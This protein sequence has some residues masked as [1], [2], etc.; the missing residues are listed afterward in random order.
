M[1]SGAEPVLLPGRAAVGLVAA[2][3][4]LGAAGIE[5]YAV[6]GGVAVTVRLGRA[7]R[8]TA[9][10]DAV[11][12]E[13]VPPD[14]VEALVE[15]EG[16]ERDPANPHRVLVADTPVELLPV[17]PL[18]DG[19]LDGLPDR[20]A[21]FAAA[22]AWALET[23][24]PVTIAAAADPAQRAIA[25][26]A[27]PAALVAMKLHAVQDR[28]GAGAVKRAGDAWDI[29]RLLVDFDADGYVRREL[30][31]APAPLPM[32]IAD[33]AERVLVADAPR[34]RSWLRQGDDAMA[35]VTI[36]E[37]RYVAHPLLDALGSGP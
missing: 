13:S 25:P 21:L 9:D 32:L 14:A 36:E 4:A 35:S 5:R 31:T 1:P 18:A 33:A 15:G 28:S 23:A 10:V 19:D 24:T 37:L 3:A 12:D 20:L 11:V 22:H 30:A 16:V 6:V 34:T 27:T 8:A 7:H 26:F 2:V 29:Y 17:Q